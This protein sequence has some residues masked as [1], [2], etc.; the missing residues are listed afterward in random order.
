MRNFTDV[1]IFILQYGLANMYEAYRTVD[2]VFPNSREILIFLQ[3]EFKCLYVYIYDSLNYNCGAEVCHHASQYAIRDE[4][5]CLKVA[6]C[7]LF[8]LKFAAFQR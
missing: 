1:F 4:N 7:I 3:S 5:K 2:S 8:S 6:N